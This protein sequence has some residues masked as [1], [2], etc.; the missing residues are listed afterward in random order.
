ME[1]TLSNQLKEAR[2]NSG[3]TQ[4]DVATILHITRQS[5]SKWERGVVYPDIENLIK[6]S[7][8]YKISIDELLN[9]NQELKSQIQLNNE[10]IKETK[11]QLGKV[12]TQLYQNSN[13]GLI[14]IALSILST[15]IPPV[16]VFLPIYV[17]WRNNKYNSLYKT[18]ILVS[19]IAIVISAI[20][21][22]VIINDNF[23]LSDTTTVY[24]FN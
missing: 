6:L 10:K 13:E 17:I 18:I 12:N 22:F 14:L 9:N 5:I 20:N 8:I 7:D 21:C 11:K 19:L 2:N 24:K 1:N 15:L 16:G 3:Y 4:N 23:P